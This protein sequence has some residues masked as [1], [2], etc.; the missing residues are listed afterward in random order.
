MLNELL[1]AF[2][3]QMFDRVQM[4]IVKIIAIFFLIMANSPSDIRSQESQYNL[5]KIYRV[6]S[7]FDLCDSS[8]ILQSTAIICKYNKLYLLC[9]KHLIF[10]YGKT[11]DSCDIFIND[12]NSDSILISG[13]ETIRFYAILDFIPYIHFS[14]KFKSDLV[15][16]ELNSETNFNW[17]QGVSLAYLDIG[18]F[19]FLDEELIANLRTDLIGDSCFIAGYPDSKGKQESIKIAR[20][21]IKQICEV[22]TCITFNKSTICEKFIITDF[23]AGS[24]ASGAPL[25]INM[26]ETDIPIGL[27]IGQIFK[28]DSTFSAFMP[29]YRIRDIIK[30]LD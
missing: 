5:K 4:M 25:I 23:L 30:E 9:N 15:A 10:R 28:G 14:N 8:K 16:I 11:A 17:P 12:L 22:D 13:P 1:N 2:G 24:G 7:Y 3:I 19:N 21:R 27:L 20:G 29:F 26:A 18:I 6:R